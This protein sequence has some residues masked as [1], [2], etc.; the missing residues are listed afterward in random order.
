VALRARCTSGGGRP[1][2]GF[3]LIEVLLSITIL[4]TV[5]TVLW[6]TFSDS[7]KLRET[8]TTRFDRM[9]QIQAALRRMQREISMAF[10][11]KIGGEDNVTNERG[12]VN[13]VT[14]F[15]GTDDR[16][17]FTNFAHIRTRI[18]QAASRQGEIAYY[19]RSVRTDEGRLRQDLVRREQSPIDG[20]PE[21]GGII[22]TLLPDV[23]SIE[24]EY[25]RPDREIAGEAWERSWDT[26]DTGVYGLPPRVRITIEVK[27]PIV[28]RKTLEFTVEAEVH[29]TQPIGFATQAVSQLPTYRIEGSVERE[30][31]SIIDP[32]SD[33]HTSD[34]FNN[35][36]GNQQR[37][38]RQQGD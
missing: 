36:E 26:R 21:S 31:E 22:Y 28:E 10:V 15:I 29:L 30:I 35:P 38:D 2:A 6:M 9:R 20:D 14:A 16:L 3:T 34:E 32:S 17:D 5:M 7:N 18:D 11:T 23:E 25:W 1:R 8:A 4:I 13:Y 37:R 33:T 12:E 24:F 27:D 19:L